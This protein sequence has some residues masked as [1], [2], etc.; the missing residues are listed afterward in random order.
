M[1]QLE[2]RVNQHAPK[3]LLESA[4]PVDEK[5]P[6]PGK[7]TRGRPRKKRDLVGVEKTDTAISLTLEGVSI[8]SEGGGKEC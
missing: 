7:R 1:Q 5:G 4:T 6:V 8:M 2:E 3:A